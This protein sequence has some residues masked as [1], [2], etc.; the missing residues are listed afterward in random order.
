MSELEGVSSAPAIPNARIQILEQ[1]SEGRNKIQ[2]AISAWRSIDYTTLMSE[3]DNTATEVVSCQRNSIVQ[4][5]DLA[6]KTKQ[7]RKLDDA[8]KLAEIKGL[9]KAYQSFIDLLTNHAKSVNSMFLKAYACL[10]E[11]PDPYPLLEA[12]LDSMIA[13]EDTLPKMAKEN[14]RLQQSINKLSTQLE[15]TEMGLQA[16]VTARNELEDAFAKRVTDVESS[17][18]AVLN[19]KQD[20]W[21]AKEKALEE[22]VDN[23]ERLLKGVKASYEVNQRLGQSI[24]EDQPSPRGYVVNAETEMLHA[25]LERTSARVAELEARNENLRLDLARTKT[26][27]SARTTALG[28]D[29]TYVRMRSENSSL[30]R[31][32]DASRKEKEGLKRD[33]DMRLGLLARDAVLLKEE[34]DGLK[35]K[36]RKWSDYDEIKQEL[37]VL[38]SIEFAT[39]EDDHV[40]I[41]KDDVGKV[42][43]TEEDSLENL[44]LARNKKLGDELTILRV[45]HQ[46]LQVK[47]EEL[48]ED[49]SQTNADLERTRLLNE[50]LESDL[51]NLQAELSNGFPSGASMAMSRY[52]PSP[53]SGKKGARTSPTSSIISGI[54]TR[55]SGGEPV[56][57]GAGILPMVTA[58]RDRFRKK[59]AQLEG[60]LS[61]CHRTV[62]QLRQQIVALQ[63]DNLNLYERARYVSTY[64]R[65][66]PSSSSSST[67]FRSNQNPSTV[68]MGPSTD[69]GVGMERYQQAYEANISPFA[70]FRGR[71]SARA[72][73]RMSLPERIVYTMTR[74]VLASRTSRNLFATYCLALHVLVFISMYWLAT[75]DIAHH[76]TSLGGAASAG[77]A[78]AGLPS[79]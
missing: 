12:S 33:L 69:A 7:F 11:A 72:Y 63:K 14:E 15:I 54:D 18:M 75:I 67:A 26:R 9:L 62:S 39:G 27:V 37:D 50:K 22:K 24:D 43:K 38:K 31:K 51:E 42:T 65:T 79:Q 71:E 4:R 21:T 68:A 73:K 35:A 74:M 58:Q 60:D 66:G 32:L 10:S 77:A 19:E 5:R 45:S 76:I 1:A 3:L 52:A 34:K 16:E 41:G 23:Q 20:N 29:P 48:Q 64:N 55:F 44:L 6:Q 25:H 61:E 47:L 59:N 36:L 17:W 46:D 8:S 57:N 30:I 56:G 2:H 28:D 53:P 70:Q 13:S 40:L 49:L 78:V